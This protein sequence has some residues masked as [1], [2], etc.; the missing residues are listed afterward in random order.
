MICKLCPTK[1]PYSKKPN[2]T[3]F[4]NKCYKHTYYQKWIANNDRSSYRKKYAKDNRVR[5]NNNKNAKYKV[6]LTFRLKESLRTR[7]AKAVR[8]N[9]K[10][11]SAVVSLGC[12]IPKLKLYLES[13]FLPGMTWDNY[14]QWHID[15]VKPLDS[16]DLTDPNQLTKACYYRNLQPLWAIDNIRKGNK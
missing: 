14:G 4:C 13:K 12:S 7:L 1:L 8:R 9:T 11:G 2:K 5:L 3:G 16:F 10:A 15:H 6:D